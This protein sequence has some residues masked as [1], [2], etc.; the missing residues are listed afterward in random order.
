MRRLYHFALSPFSRRTR[1]VLA[2]RKLEV[3]LVDA[4]DDA[5]AKAAMLRLYPLRT[6]PVLVEDDG[7]VVADSNAIAEYV[8]RAYSGAPLWPKD[9]REILRV[10]QVMALTDGALNTV[11]DLGTRYYSL[12]HDG[13]W[14]A[15]LAEKLGRAQ[16]ALDALGALV[17]GSGRPNLSAAGWTIGDMWLY[18]AIAWLEGLP[19][20]APTFANASQVL[21]LGWKLPEPLSRWASAHHEHPDVRAL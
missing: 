10:S 4:R 6:A 12:R 19:A 7:G 15:V 18:T 21:S 16:G 8:D 13:A 1:L 3:L 20:R 14:P 2:H 5:E 17:S 9:P 11:I